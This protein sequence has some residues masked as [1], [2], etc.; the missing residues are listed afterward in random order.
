M[1]TVPNGEQNYMECVHAIIGGKKIA[2]MKYG[3]DMGYAAPRTAIGT[4]NGSFA[5][6]VS[7]D[8]RKPEQLRD[9]LYSSGWDNAIMMD[10]GG[11]TCFMDSEG[12]GFTGDGRVIPFFLIW[13]RK[14]GTH[15]KRKEKNRW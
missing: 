4:K 9:L 11:S 8:R 1:K 13:K 14:A 7:Q 5:Y 6:Y 3:K 15:L 10:G 12:N 2:P